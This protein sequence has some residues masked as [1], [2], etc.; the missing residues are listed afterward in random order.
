MTRVSTCSAEGEMMV[1]A[2]HV[3]DIVLATKSDKQMAEVKKA[4]AEGV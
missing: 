4:L 3:D 1:I 2:V